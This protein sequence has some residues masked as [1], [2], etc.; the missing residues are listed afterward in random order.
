[1]VLYPESSD[2]SPGN[3][4][5]DHAIRSTFATSSLGRIEI[6]NEYLDVTR[7]PGADYQQ[8][9]AEFLRRKYAGRKVQL[10]IAGLS[11]ALDFALKYRAQTFP[12]IPVVFCA[13]DQREIQ[14]RN[15][16]PDVIGVPVRMDLTGTLELALRLHPDTRS[17][18]V[19][20]GNASFDSYWEA[21]ARQRF[22]QYEDKLK[23]VYLSGLPTEDLLK[24]VAQLPKQ[25]IIYYL[26]VFRDGAGKILIPADVLER[27]ASVANSPI[28]GHID[29]YV[30]R[31]IVGGRVISFATEGTNATTLGLRILAGERPENIGVQ[32]TSANTDLFDW[33]QLRRWG[34]SEASLPPGSVVRD[35]A[36]SFWDVY[37]WLIIGVIS[38]CAVE[39]LLIVGLLAQRASRRRAESRFRQVVE[40]APSGMVM[41]GQDGEIVLANAQ[42]EKLFG[43]RRE[44]LLGH[45]VEML[46]P[47]RFRNHHVAHRRGFFASPEDRSMGAGLDLFARRKDGSE[48]PVEIRLSAVHADTGLCV[49][50]SIIDISERRRAA[51][52]LRE[53]QR[54]LQV[55]TGKLLHSQETERRRIARELHDDLNQ[56]LALLSVDLDLL[57]RQHLGAP[58]QLAGRIQEL[59]ARVKQLS[60]YVHGLSHQLHPSK[61]EQLGLL[62]AVRGLCKELT[63]S[64]SLPIAFTHHELPD[65]LPEDTA[66]CLYRIAQEALAN[67]VKHSGARH[68]RV[69]L[70]RRAGT[71]FLRIADDGVGFDPKIVDA[72]GGLGLVS[73]RERLRLVGGQITIDSRPSGGTRIAVSVPLCNPDQ[74]EGALPAEPAPL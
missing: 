55:L 8:L 49:L 30:G 74:R 35:K 15:L 32:Q 16:P 6:H 4:L 12:G 21:E 9:Q 40:A 73:M 14:A 33:R 64:H 20:A 38:V 57:S 18:Y 56:S 37:K 60:S 50:A 67:V 51:D 41:V 42:M 29:S 44:E 72:N 19:I 7:S 43:Y 63:G 39:A 27:V 66:L 58:D 36:L 61:L 52:G 65:A 1:V 2:G 54:E 5:V 28:Y 47:E 46:L 26:H 53:S 10:L 62:P 34:I 3:A 24:Q 11:S 13:V 22:R 68:A 70:T 25:S 59:C 23:F 71:V 69:E 48:F 17:V 45:P 31:G